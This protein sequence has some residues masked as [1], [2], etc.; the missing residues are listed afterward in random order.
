M[1]E[2]GSCCQSCGGFVVDVFL[3]VWCGLFR[4]F[5]LLLF[6]INAMCNSEKK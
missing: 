1:S 6:L 4:F 3:C 5:L 2:P